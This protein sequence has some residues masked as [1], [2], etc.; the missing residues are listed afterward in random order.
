VLASAHNAFSSSANCLR[1][2]N[3]K[4]EEEATAVVGATYR[5]LEIRW[6]EE[7]ATSTSFLSSRSLPVCSPGSHDLTSAGLELSSALRS[8]FS[9]A[10]ASR[11]KEVGGAY[12]N[13][14]REDLSAIL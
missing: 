6:N 5:E 1:S 8:I 3:S 4:L 12:E 13:E 9:E 11:F 7:P 14:E 2:I 10:F